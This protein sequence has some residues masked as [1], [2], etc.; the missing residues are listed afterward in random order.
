MTPKTNLPAGPSELLRV[1]DG[2]VL[3]QALYA[4]AKLGV[5]DRLNDGPRKTRDLATQLE[6]QESPTIRRRAIS[7]AECLTRC[8]PW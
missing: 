8:G 1:R 3:H 2:L 7:A 5:A 6:V 4:A